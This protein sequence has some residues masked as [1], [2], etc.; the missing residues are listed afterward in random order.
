MTL[1]QLKEEARKEFDEKFDEI[2]KKVIGFYNQDIPPEVSKEIIDFI[3]SFITKA[4]KK[5][6]EEGIKISRRTN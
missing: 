6:I 2:R 3:D 4:Y 5:G 1:Q